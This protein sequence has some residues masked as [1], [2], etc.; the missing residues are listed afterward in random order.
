MEG[1]P[2]PKPIT[3]LTVTKSEP[4]NLVK[5]P[6]NFLTEGACFFS[7]P[8]PG[9]N[10]GILNIGL[11]ARRKN[12]LLEP[13]LIFHSPYDQ[14]IPLLKPDNVGNRQVFTGQRD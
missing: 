13:T 8:L 11:K 12:F 4:P 10:S 14:V 2:M 1:R 7:S 9:V 3:P 6:K 5:S